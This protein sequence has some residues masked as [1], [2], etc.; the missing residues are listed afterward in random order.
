MIAILADGKPLSYGCSTERHPGQLLVR[1][2]VDTFKDMEIAEDCL[3]KSI[4]RDRAV[5]STWYKDVEFTFVAVLN[6]EG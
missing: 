4:G 6:T 2:R 1:G 3:S 5:G